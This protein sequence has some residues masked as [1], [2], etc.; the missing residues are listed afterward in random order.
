MNPRRGYADTRHGQVHHQTAGEGPALLLLHA[1]PRSSRAY[2]KL[3]PHLAQ[4]CR[5]IA[6]D[7]LGFGQSDPLP[8]DV[9][10]ADLAESMVDLLDAVGVEQAAVFGLHTGNKI[11]AALA[12]NYPERVARL[13]LC[14]MTHSIIIDQA[15]REE[16]IR[17]I[18]A[19]HPIDL[20]RA[21]D[22]EKLDRIQAAD[23]FAAIYTA[24]YAFD[25]AAALPSLPMPCLVVELATA[26]EAHLGRQAGQL[27]KMIPDCVAVTLEHS[28]RDVLE[29]VPGTLA[30][31][32]V[33]FLA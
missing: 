9:T 6:P 5:V 28:D 27:V 25:L 7:T 4:H 24:N 32:I 21:E 20:M 8:V 14:G 23:S 17:E 22:S 19:A 18:L 13:I 12:A 30:N 10:L 15:M 29:R 33:R 1:T 26:A 11:A 31:T 16:A 2:Q 3:I